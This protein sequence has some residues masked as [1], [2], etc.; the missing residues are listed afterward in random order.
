MR[1]RPASA[2]WL[3]RSRPTISQY[4]GADVSRP[5]SL[6][7]GANAVASSRQG[8]CRIKIARIKFREFDQSI[9]VVER[10]KSV[11]KTYHSIFS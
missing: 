2:R 8:P 9:I 3:A 1:E 6:R 4:A 11:T 10:N 5:S 7:M